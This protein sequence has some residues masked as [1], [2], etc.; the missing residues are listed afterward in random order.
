MSELWSRVGDRVWLRHVLLATA[1]SGAALLALITYETGAFNGLERQ[2]VDARFSIR[3]PERP[4]HG[5]VIIGVD[6]K[7]LTAINARPVPGSPIPR[8]YYARLLDRVRAARPR[9]IAIDA[10]FI[11]RSDAKDDNALL[12]AIRRDG[13]VL[14]ATHDTTAGPIPVPAG[15][16][17]ASGALL[18]SAAVDTD[19]DG[20]LRRMIYRAVNLPTLAVIAAEMLSGRPVSRSEFPDNHAWVNFRGPPGTYP[21]YSAIDVLNGAIAPALLS[22]RT[23][24]I[25]VTDPGE[26]D[27]FVTAS[28]SNPMAG[29]EFHA[30]ALQTILD[31]FPLGAASGGI[32]IVL[33]F[34]LAAIP[35]VLSIR[36]SAILVLLAA[37]VTLV[38][39]LI[40]V[41][42][43]FNSGTIVTVPDPILA[44]AL[45]TAGAIAADAFVQR[46]QLR[47][48]QA[49]FELLPSPVSDFFISYR[50]E[51]SETAANALRE[52]LV[53][54]FGEESVFLDTEQI[55]YGQQWPQRLEDAV[56]AC[57]A[58]LVLIGPDWSEATD[59]HGSQRLTNPDDWVRCEI[60]AALANDQIAVVPVLHD[61]AVA[62]TRELLPKGLRRLAHLQAVSFTG[63]RQE[64]WIDEL[65][66]SI[67]KGR[68]REAAPTRPDPLH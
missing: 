55:D 3:G 22:G 18:A 44:L 68:L 15:V 63:K 66:D 41:Q 9:L 61:R 26:K 12:A 50:R 62:P 53:R 20:V 49:I 21:T 40:A 38:I 28:S 6:Q 54:K 52:A 51:Q 29:V 36:L 57:R 16:R 14:L 1:A 48:L 8:I 2:S 19:P 13:P 10:Q 27:V 42:L 30:N 60:R 67:H 35:A 47:N 5:I 17:N 46:R 4:G 59:S 64:E 31:G 23:V 11:G 39:F 56:A 34:V 24:L 33:L 7:T 58:M 37:L 45:G 25:G 32:E 43:A 65:A